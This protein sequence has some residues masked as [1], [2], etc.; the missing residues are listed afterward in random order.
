MFDV[1]DAAKYPLRGDGAVRTLAV[2]GGVPAL[3]NVVWTAILLAGVLF[4]PL[5]LLALPLVPIQIAIGV[6]WTGYFVRVGRRTLAGEDTPPAFGDWG[7]LARDGFWGVVVVVAYHVPL[8]VVVGAGYGALFLVVLG[9][10][11]LAESGAG[12]AAAGVGMLGAV[13]VVALFLFGLVYSLAM[14]YLLPASLLAYADEGRV[15]AAFSPGRLRTVALSEAYA[16]PWVVAA[17]A[18]AAVLL[19]VTSL[20]AVLVGFLL[21]PLVPVFNF[22]LG[23]ATFYALARAY[24]ERTGSTTGEPAAERRAAPDRGPEDV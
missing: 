15:G 7:A 22:Y 13:V 2:G 10:G 8:V 18:Y 20:T 6:I 16:I 3:V 17:T 24:A 14:S 9:S 5:L 1:E 11:G 4:A 21:L 19:A 12:E 23:S